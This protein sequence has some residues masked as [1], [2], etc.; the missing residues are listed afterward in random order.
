VSEQLWF[1]QYLS[2]KRLVEEKEKLE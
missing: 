2:L 1:L